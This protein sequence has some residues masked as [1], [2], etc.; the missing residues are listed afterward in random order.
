M[1]S[2]YDLIV[3]GAGLGG[4][5]F[6]WHLIAAGG[7]PRRVL[8]IDRSFEPTNDRTWC[9]WGPR[10]APFAELAVARWSEAEVCFGGERHTDSLGDLRYHCIPSHDFRQHVLDRID[11]TPWITRVEA[12]IFD[13]G[14]DA[15]GAFVD[16][17]AGRFT[18]EWMLQSLRY[19]GDSATRRLR[20][21][22][23]Q[24]FGGLEIRTARPVFDP[25][26]LTLMDFRVP[27][28]D[29]TTFVYVLPFAP[30]RALVEHTMFSPRALPASRHFELAEDYI[31]ERFD[32]P[33]EVLRRE[34]GNIPMDD[35]FPDQQASSRVFQIGVVGG[36]IKPSTGYTFARVQRHASAL[37]GHF[38]TTGELAVQPSSGPRFRL[39]DTLLLRIL[40]DEPERAEGVFRELLTRSPLPLALRFLDEQTTL[41]DEARLFAKLPT[42][43][44][45]S[46]VPTTLLSGRTLPPAGLMV[47]LTVLVCWASSFVIGLGGWHPGAG[48]WPADLAWVALQAFLS[49]GVFITAHDAM[50][51]LVVPGNK[52]MNTWVGRICTWGYAGLD[53]DGLAAAHL[54]HHSKPAT[55]HDPDYYRIRPNPVS[56]YFDFMWQYLSVRQLVWLVFLWVALLNVV[57]LQTGLMFWAAPLMLSTLQL[58]LVGTWWVH[59][60]GVYL[61]DGPL[62]ARSLDV[63]PVLSF[64]AC[65]H[66]GYHYEHHA[67]PDLPWWRLWQFRGLRVAPPVTARERAS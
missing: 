57:D 20:Y 46:G 31:R 33:F 51:G 66:F 17:S 42:W 30:D 29:G 41:S 58:F 16:T 53:Y 34:S 50:H 24:H 67:R 45:L 65:Y 60:P 11:A 43:P 44:F 38:A 25:S 5:S 37:A 8:V 47:A 10:D 14:E 4:L 39:Y 61:G 26:R 13:L 21:P 35:R 62:R 52:R 9:F 48:S 32:V 63:H 56:W 2:S 64:F 6:L 15:S 28:Q 55:E 12:N 59:R 40:H 3:A 19:L 1:S 18:G 27:Q 22:V 36:Q 23:R 7:P 49:T 54:V